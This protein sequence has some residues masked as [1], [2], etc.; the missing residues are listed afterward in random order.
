MNKAALHL[1]EEMFQQEESIFSGAKD[2]VEAHLKAV[3]LISDFIGKLNSLL[4]E[5]SFED[6]AEEIHFFKEIR[7]AFD[8]RLLFHLH[9]LNHHD[10]N[11]AGADRLSFCRQQLKDLRDYE[12]RNRSFIHYLLSPQGHL[13]S[14]Y[15]LR[16]D[17]VD[18]AFLEDFGYVYD[19]HLY[20]R[21]SARQAKLKVGKLLAEIY[22]ECLMD[23]EGNAVQAPGNTE[24]LVWEGNKVW[25]AELIYAFYAT[26]VFGKVDLQRVVRFVSGAFGVRFANAY[27]IFEEIRMRKKNRTS[28]LDFMRL[29]LIRRM[30]LDDE[31]SL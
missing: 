6:E 4:R 14:Y 21:M 30:D 22:L 26:G 10:R 3:Q 1:Y 11:L 19:P 25:L 20:A 2:V 9:L 29:N 5:R 17:T 8:G 16:T 31:F 7:P 24:R 28:F 23:A 27:K 18:P 12:E 13:D 15:F